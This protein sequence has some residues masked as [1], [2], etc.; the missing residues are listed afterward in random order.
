M[1]ELDLDA[2][3]DS[4]LM[5]RLNMQSAQEEIARYHDFYEGPP[6]PGDE[7]HWFEA[8]RTL[9]NATSR[10]LT[11]MLQD[12][13]ALRVDDLGR[14]AAAAARLLRAEA[15]GVVLSATGQRLMELGQ[16]TEALPHLDRAEQLLGESQ[17]AVDA[18]V[19]RLECLLNLK[20]F[21]EANAYT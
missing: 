15:E 11:R 8:L 17:D 9:H 14:I 7:E 19:Q 5:G 1:M 4:V 12:T 13:N 16:A 6:A 2:V 3:V 21:A 10:L 18:A 20:R